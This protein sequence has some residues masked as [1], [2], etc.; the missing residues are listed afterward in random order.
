MLRYAPGTDCR[1]NCREGGG[2]SVPP[3]QSPVGALTFLLQETVPINGFNQIELHSEL[4]RDV[5]HLGQPSQML[6]PLIPWE[7][8]AGTR[9]SFSTWYTQK[10]GILCLGKHRLVRCLRHTVSHKKNEISY[11]KDSLGRGQSG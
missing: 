4:C 8:M 6:N 11:H 1:M 2:C 3:P 5:G 7:N 9:L 10:L